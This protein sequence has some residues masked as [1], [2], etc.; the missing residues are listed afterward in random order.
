MAPG[1]LWLVKLKIDKDLIPPH[2]IHFVEG[3]SKHIWLENFIYHLNLQ[4]YKQTLLT[5]EPFGDLHND[6]STKFQELKIVIT[7]SSKAKIITALKNLTKELRSSEKVV[8][9]AMGHRTGFISG[10]ATLYTPAIFVLSHTQQPKFF[11]IMQLNSKL[12]GTMH[13][14]AYRFYTRRANLI[15]S[16][17][18]EVRNELN[19]FKLNEKNILDLSFGINLEPLKRQLQVSMAEVSENGSNCSRVLMVGRLAPEKSY[20]LALNAFSSCLREDPAAILTIA[21]IGPQKEYLE[22]LAINLGIEKNVKFLGFVENIP[23]LMLNS[24]VL[25]HLSQTESYGQIYI[26]ALIC[27][28]P[29]IC[30]KTG[31]AI[32]LFAQGQGEFHL[33]DDSTKENV[34]SEL[35]KFFSRRR[36]AR[37]H[38]QITPEF[39]E[40]HSDRYVYSRLSNAFDS[41]AN[42]KKQ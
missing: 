33:L 32:D 25:L 36:T 34:S 13:Q 41:L 22:N 24:D 14:S 42:T 19:K 29:V 26:E 6:F 38:P 20:T 4:G 9:F 15:L 8:V 1:T 2:I 10:L 12:R 21:G 35:V 27:G 7:K 28:L 16:F 18:L 39:L 5:I 17:S 11:K 3:N 40:K 23:E 30:T 31:V 37:T